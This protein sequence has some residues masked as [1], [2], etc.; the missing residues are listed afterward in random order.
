[1][2]P[3][4]ELNQFMSTYNGPRIGFVDLII[5]VIIYLL[6]RKPINATIDKLLT[7]M[8]TSNAEKQYRLL[9][10]GGLSPEEA[11]AKVRE[12]LSATLAAND[13]FPAQ[14]APVT[15]TAA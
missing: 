2:D 15:P 10:K 7:R 3:A 6:F 8:N 13:P 14:V 4:M 9:R 1:M 11:A 12:N 5:V